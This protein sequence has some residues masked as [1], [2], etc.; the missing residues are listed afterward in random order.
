[1]KRKR[2]LLDQSDD[3]DDVTVVEWRRPKKPARGDDKCRKLILVNIVVFSI[4]IVPM[5]AI[6]H[7]NHENILSGLDK[8]M[9]ER[10]NSK[11]WKPKNITSLTTNLERYFFGQHIAKSLILSALTRR[12]QR[13]KAYTKALVMSFHGWTGS[14]KNYLAK[15]IADSLFKRGIKS[16]FVQSFVS[17]V[18]FHDAKLADDYKLALKEWIL[19]NVTRCAETLFIFDEVDKMPAGVLDVLK[20]FMDHHSVINGVDMS[21]ATFI[22]LSN[23]GGRQITRT[24]FELWQAGKKREEIRYSDYEEMILNGAFNEDGGLQK[25]L[26]IDRSLIDIY[27][28]FLPLEHRHVRQCI[29]RELEDRGLDVSDGTANVLVDQVISELTFWPPDIKMYSSTGCKRIVQK[30][31]EV[32]YDQG[33]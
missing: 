18:H 22:L 20:P 8:I 2:E 24:T 13:E 9:G 26:L 3:E 29:E 10:C 25:S 5:I 33:L 11:I 16:T 31:D 28:P 14:G 7:L 32:L 1:M 30:V 23:T 6:S 19:T 21:Q 4:F 27:V 15:F 12:W 17:T